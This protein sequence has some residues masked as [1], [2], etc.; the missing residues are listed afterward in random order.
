MRFVSIT[1]VMRCA[2]GHGSLQIQYSAIT[3]S[4]CV[5]LNRTAFGVMEFTQRMHEHRPI[6]STKIPRSDAYQAWIQPHTYA[7]SDPTFCI[8]ALQ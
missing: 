4:S 3:S 1:G 5:S 2:C 6:L 8:G 7:M